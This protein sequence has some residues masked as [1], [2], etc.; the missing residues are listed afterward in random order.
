MVAAVDDRGPIPSA[1]ATSIVD[2][3]TATNIAA[4]AMLSCSTPRYTP[5]R[6]CVVGMSVAIT[7]TGE[8]DAHASPTAPMVFA[9]PGP[10]VVSATPSPPVA[11][12]RP[13]AA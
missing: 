5:G 6:R 13:S 10:V 3:V 8:C 12:A 11:R 7:T 9:A 2:F 1:S 4:W